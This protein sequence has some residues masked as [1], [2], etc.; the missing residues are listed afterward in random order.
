MREVG[1]LER[2]A[3]R[4]AAKGF[5][6]IF[7]YVLV[8]GAIVGPPF[9]AWNQHVWWGYVLAVLLAVLWTIPA[10]V[11]AIIAVVR[12]AGLSK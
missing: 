2:K 12:K 4:A 9:L 3:E 8:A 5:W 11:V 6:G 1:Y 10:T 7:L